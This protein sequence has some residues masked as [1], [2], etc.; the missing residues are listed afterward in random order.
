M[1]IT[2]QKRAARD[3]QSK[4]GQLELLFE[5]A[6]AL[7]RAREPHEIY[8]AT[9]HGLAQVLA[10]DRAAVLIFDSDDVLRFKEWVDLSQEYRAAVE[11]HTPWKR[12]S[13]EAQPIA[14]SDAMQDASISTYRQVHAKEG[15]RAGEIVRQL[16][17]YSG[18]ESPTFEPVDVSLLIE[19]MLELLK[20]SIPKHAI[21]KIDLGK[22]IPAVL[23]N[24]TQI[25]QIVMN[26]ITNASEAIGECT[27]VIGISTSLARVGPGSRESDA[28]DLPEDY[29]AQMEISDTGPGMTLDV[30][31][32]IF[33]PFFTTKFPG[34]GRGLGSR[35]HMGLCGVMEARST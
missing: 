17:M 16:M 18:K 29:Y 31:D 33:D 10:A 30:Q 20:I 26:L 28:G 8:S 19:E 3:H 21:L 25:R 24:P 34:R 4:F 11:G 22:N 15:I 14:V 1:S 6:S 32:K 35:S 5:L 12:G 9:V 2:G 27:G 23:A 7:S 13:V